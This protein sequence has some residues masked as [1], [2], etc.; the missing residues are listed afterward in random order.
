MKKI[1]LLAALACLALPA[2]QVY[3]EADEDYKKAVNLFE[4]RQ[5]VVEAMQLLRP[6]AEAGHA[7][8]QALYG[9][10]FDIAEDDSEAAKYYRLAADQGNADGIYGLAVLTMEGGGGLTKDVA[11]AK[12][13]F[14]SAAEKGH[15]GSITA[16]ASAVLGKTLG[17]SESDA[18][19]ENFKWVELAA[20]AEHRLSV[21]AL[22][23]AY[24]VGQYGKQIN[25]EEAA[26]WKQV[27]SKL[28]GGEDQ[29]EPPKKRRRLR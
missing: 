25:A 27:L 3:A 29:K 16:L 22:V 1:L 23:A 5:D 24:T 14:V 18:L 12:A 2:M 15:H 17:F 20:A 28:S 8:S 9:Y 11:A 6:L 19:G 4:K 26:K 7:P 13:L 10:M 21:E